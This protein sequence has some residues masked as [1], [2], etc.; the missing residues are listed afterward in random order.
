MFKDVSS[1]TRKT[2]NA[3]GQTALQKIATQST[4]YIS[5]GIKA[6]YFS[7]DNKA[8]F[9]TLASDIGK[10]RSLLNT[11][12]KHVETTQ[13]GATVV[14]TAGTGSVYAINPP[15]EGTDAGNRTGRSIKAIRFDVSGEF[16]YS[17]GTVATTSLQRQ[18]FNWYLVRNK[19]TSSSSGTT[20]FV[21]A[22]ILDPDS[23]SVYTPMSMMDPDNIVDFEI[24]QCGQEVVDLRFNTTAPSSG[25]KCFTFSHDCSLHQSFNNTTAASVTQ[26]ACFLMFTAMNPVNT[27]GVSTVSFVA[28]EWFVDN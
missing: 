13:N 26:N 22:D 16:I 17:T 11:E 23:N 25:H 2:R 1:N 4:S 18:T 7:K 8:N 9:A 15:A 20:P 3:R 14:A 12:R 6:R 5:D 28:R 19:S 10:L 27:G 21:V 24:M